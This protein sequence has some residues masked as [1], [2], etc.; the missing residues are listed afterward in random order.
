L[1]YFIFIA[2]SA[3]NMQKMGAAGRRHVPDRYFLT[4]LY[5]LSRRALSGRALV[6]L[7]STLTSLSVRLV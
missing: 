1:L 2:S 5:I 7:T 4:E 3:E 6:T